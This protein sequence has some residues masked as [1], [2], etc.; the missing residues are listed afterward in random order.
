MRKGTEE[1]EEE[2]EEREGRRVFE[3]KQSLRRTQN[4]SNCMPCQYEPITSSKIK[5]VD[6]H[7]RMPTIKEE[8][9]ESPV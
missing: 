8:K 5:N 1:P 6:V 3:K 7:N 4:Y 2:E 9:F